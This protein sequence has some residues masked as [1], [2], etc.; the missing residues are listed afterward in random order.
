MA[1]PRGGTTGPCPSIIVRCCMMIAAYQRG[2]KYLQCYD[3]SLG[4]YRGQWLQSMRH[5]FGIRHSVAY[6]LAVRYRHKAAVASK[7]SMLTS[8]SDNED[9]AAIRRRDERLD[10]E[11]G[12]FVLLGR[13]EH[14]GPPLEVVPEGGKLRRTLARLK[15]PRSTSD[16]SP[17]SHGSAS[18]AS[19]GFGRHRTPDG[20][21][22]SQRASS[23]ELED[24]YGSLNTDSC[25]ASFIS[26]V[27]ALG[28]TQQIDLSIFITLV[29]C[30]SFVLSVSDEL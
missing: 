13:V 23:E 8:A 28:T 3:L 26:Q 17:G 18:R 24:H 14:R 11:R 4:S 21:L 29:R 15:K 2:R 1:D 27:S 16:M 6:T 22:H 12:G 19:P 20:S 7:S 9:N 30:L 25:N 10:S 5:G